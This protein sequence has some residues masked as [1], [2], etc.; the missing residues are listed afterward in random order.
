MRVISQKRLEMEWAVA[1]QS[2]ALG[3]MRN[4]MEGE[5]LSLEDWTVPE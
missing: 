1:T 5:G 2:S 4:M 3:E